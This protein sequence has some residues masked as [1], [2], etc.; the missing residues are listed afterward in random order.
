MTGKIT[1]NDGEKAVREWPLEQIIKRNRELPVILK[2]I[3]V[4]L[5]TW[6][7]FDLM[8]PFSKKNWDCNIGS[9]TRFANDSF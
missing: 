2:E 3:L 9:H 7:L 6:D 1:K 5:T 4:A 8:Q